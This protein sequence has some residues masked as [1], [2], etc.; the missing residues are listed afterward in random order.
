[1]LG[2]AILPSS[3]GRNHAADGEPLRP[4]SDQA[5]THKVVSFP[6]KA[7][8]PPRVQITSSS[9]YRFNQASTTIKSYGPFCALPSKFIFQ[10][11]FFWPETRA[12][13]SAACS[14]AANVI[15]R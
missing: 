7:I 13:Q 5:A 2:L 12:C 9:T 8:S 11:A 6:W 10:T 14:A 1:M 15:V 3:E 4:A